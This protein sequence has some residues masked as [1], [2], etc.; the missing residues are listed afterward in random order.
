MK[1]HRGYVAGWRSS[2][3]E[4]SIACEI[5]LSQPY[6]KQDSPTLPGILTLTFENSDVDGTMHEFTLTAT[7]IAQPDYEGMEQGIALAG[8]LDEPRGVPQRPRNWPL[9]V[10]IKVVPLHP[11]NCGM[12]AFFPQDGSAHTPVLRVYA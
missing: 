11:I 3:V 4:D 1:V 7:V 8:I 12:G 10:G 9:L 2:F 6:Y 5:P